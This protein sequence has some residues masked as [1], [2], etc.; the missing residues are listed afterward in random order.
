MKNLLSIAVV[1]A[2]PMFANAEIPSEHTCEKAL[3]AG[4]HPINKNLIL[5]SEEIE[6]SE[7]SHQEHQYVLSLIY[8]SDTETYSAN[9]SNDAG[10]YIHIVRKSDC[11]ALWSDFLVSY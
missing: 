9:D 1:M 7:L 11:S 3:A 2:L 5:Q 8:R 6:Y 4:F 10:F